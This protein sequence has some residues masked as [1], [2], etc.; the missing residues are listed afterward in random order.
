MQAVDGA[1][2]TVVGQAQIDAPH[3]LVQTVDG[4]FAAV[5]G[6]ARLAA[7]HVAVQ[8]IDGLLAAAFGDPAF[9][10]DA[11]RLG[12]A[13]ALEGT[14]GT[15]GGDQLLGTAQGDGFDPRC[16]EGGIG[17]QGSKGDGEDQRA[18]HGSGSRYSLRGAI[19]CSGN[20]IGKRSAPIVFIDV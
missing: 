12:L 10:L 18:F 14:V 1:L 11:R 20:S 13:Q 5:L 15:V 2:A 9:F 16:G 19:L 8:A 7:G 17:G 6:Q 3:V 4:L